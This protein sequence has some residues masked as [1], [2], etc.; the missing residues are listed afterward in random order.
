MAYNLQ[1]PPEGPE[2]WFGSPY[3]DLR[4]ERQHESGIS[5]DL[6]LAPQLYMPCPKCGQEPMW[7]PD[8]IGGISTACAN[9]DCERFRLLYYSPISACPRCGSDM[10]LSATSASMQCEDPTCHQPPAIR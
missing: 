4:F 6:E 1:D 10:R 5:D 8:A 3:D 7:I 9:P 2:E